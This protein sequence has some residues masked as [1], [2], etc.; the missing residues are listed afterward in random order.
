ME[1]IEGAKS[2]DIKYVIQIGCL[3]T[4]VNVPLWDT[5]VILR[6]IGILTLLTQLIGR[7]LR[8]LKPH[9]EDAGIVKR[10]ALVLDYTDTIEAMG[11]IYDDPIVQQAMEQ[12]GSAQEGEK[13]ECPICSTMNSEFAVR[14]VGQSQSSGYDRD[15]ET[16]GSS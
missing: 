12:K 13:Q 10:D 4:G 14:C 8:T 1:I 6:K 11:N 5:S 16:I 2:G 3:T 7:V 15:W 9:Q